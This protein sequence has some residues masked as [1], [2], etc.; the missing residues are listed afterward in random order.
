MAI[1]LVQDIPFLV[2]DDVFEW[3]RNYRWHSR[4]KDSRFYAYHNTRRSGRNYRIG[5]HREV[6]LSSNNDG[7]IV[8]HIDGNTQDCRREN[9]RVV[10]AK[11]SAHNTRA[12][13][14][15]TS[16]FKGVRRSGVKGKWRATIKSNGKTHHLGSF[17]SEEQ[18]ALAYD[19][20][21]RPIHGT[22]GRY[23]FP[24]PGERSALAPTD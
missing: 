12:K 6:M 9:L 5:L 14:R 23:N 2:D 15:H 18:A 8:D 13:R 10:S 20:A 21:A 24:L 3:A 16:R 1:L 22:Y 4:L 7:R 17:A 11:Q 19:A